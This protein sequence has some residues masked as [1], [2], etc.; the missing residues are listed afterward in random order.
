MESIKQEIP[1]AQTADNCQVSGI[2]VVVL[3]S[4]GPRHS[5]F[6]WELS[7]HFDLKGIVLDDRYHISDRLT[8]FLKL[9]HFNPF[10][11]IR[12]FWLKV[13]IKPYEE[14]DRSIENRFFVRGETQPEFP[15]AVSLWST[16]DPNSPATVDRIRALNPDVIAVFGTR[17]ILNP[18]LSLAHLGALNIHTG[19]SPYYRGG[20][21]TFWC[22]ERGDLEHLGVTIHHLT[23]RIDGGDIVYTAQPDLDPEDTVRTIECKLIFLGTQKMIEAIHALAEDKAPRI[24]QHEKGQLFLSKMFTLR[25]RLAFEKKMERGWLRQLIKGR[26]REAIKP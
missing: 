10:K 16:P 20:Q 5:Y 24:K 12:A 11:M 14:R 18:V 21:C 2:S 15:P 25:A 4:R 13:R 8:T 9:N 7:K 17:M 3:T 22:L 6:C 23:E 26:T 19:L 1:T